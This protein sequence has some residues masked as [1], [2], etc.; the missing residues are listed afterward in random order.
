M[1]RDE[2][3]SLPPALALAFLYDHAPAALAD[4]IAA[5]P[6]PKIPMSPKYDYAVYTKG[7]VCW[8]SEMD[9]RELAFWIS[10]SEGGD[11]KYEESNAKRLKALSFWLEWRRLFPQ[12]IWTGERNR[13]TVTAAAPSAKPTVYPKE[14]REQQAQQQST[15]PTFSDDQGGDDDDITF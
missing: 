5:E 9:A 13:R 6:P 3:C 14:P 1:T 4:A 2:W 8:A 7:G 15:A 10:R 12:A 11:P